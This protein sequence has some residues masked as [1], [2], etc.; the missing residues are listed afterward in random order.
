M[1][2][3]SL[4]TLEVA[5]PVGLALSTQCE[6][7]AAPSVQGEFGVFPGHLPLLAALRGGIIKYRADNRDHVAAVGPGF[8]EAEPDKVLLL[9]E[10]FAL[11][12]EIDAE[13]VRQEL[14]DA[15]Q[16]LSDLHE[17]HVGSAYEVI[18]R[19]IDWCHAR[20]ALAAHSQS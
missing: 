11:P 3:E 18:Q 4:L 5:T 20:L 8:I 12:E 16:R 9:T 10:R 19:D 6:S 1:A 17:A 14:A 15:E 7:I 13:Q 2:S